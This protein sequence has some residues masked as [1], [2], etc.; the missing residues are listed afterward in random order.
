[1]KSNPKISPE[2]GSNSKSIIKKVFKIKSKKKIIGIILVIAVVIGGTMYSSKI[3]TLGISTLDSSKYIVLKSG[4]NINKIE[5]KGEVT[6]DDATNVYSQVNIPIKEINVDIGDIVKAGDVLAILD[7]TKLEEEIKELEEAIESNY[8]CNKIQLENAKEIYDEALSLSDENANGDIKNAQT[9]VDAA[10]LDLDKK[11]KDY[12]DYSILF[13]NGGVSQKDI[14]EVKLLY[15]NAKLTYD[16]AVTALNNIKSKV[17]LNLTTSEKNYEAAKIQFND[18]S[19]KTSLENKKKDLERAVIK[20]PIDGMISVKNASVG[21]VAQGDLF[22]IKDAEDTTITVNVKEVDIEKIKVGQKAEI[23]TDSTG[24]NII[25]GEVTEVSLIAKKEDDDLLNLKSDDAE[26]EFEVK[27]KIT[28]SN[29]KLKLGMKA[30]VNIITEEKEDAYIVPNESII[31][32]KDD[33]D[34]LYILEKNGDIYIVKNIEI[35]KGSVGELNTEILSDYL[36]DD[37]IILKNPMD[38]EIGSKIKIKES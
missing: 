33:N 36:R 30:K 28:D 1:M 5:V 17:Q 27:V 19:Q 4:D 29:Y 26:A 35:T 13:E 37:L 38:Y 20:A 14:E 8:A 2:I 18:Q 6:G 3:M 31:K 9:A 24:S 11:E 7:T 21:N 25:A 16:N 34:S 15:D 22:Q 32:D 10:K 12:E 23:K